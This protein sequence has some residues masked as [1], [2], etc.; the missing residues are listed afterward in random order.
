MHRAVAKL[1]PK[2]ALTQETTSK[3]LPPSHVAPSQAPASSKPV[4]TMDFTDSDDG[5]SL[6]TKTLPKGN[7]QQIFKIRS[8][9]NSL[10]NLSVNHCR[11]LSWRK[12]CVKV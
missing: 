4:M 10:N 3:D 5:F 9:F 7:Q 2:A 8:H 6:D 11:N 12:Y 1:A